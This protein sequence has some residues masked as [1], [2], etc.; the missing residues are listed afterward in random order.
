TR[1]REA[2][3]AVGLHQPGGDLE[4]CRLA[5]AVAPHQTHALAL[6]D[7]KLRALEQRRAAEGE[8]DVLQG[9]ERWRHAA[10]LA[11]SAARRNVYS[12]SPNRVDTSVASAAIT[13]FASGPVAVTV[14]EVPIPAASIIRPMIESPPTL[15]ALRETLTVA[16][17]FS[18]SCTNFADARACRP[19][20]LTIFITRVTA[21]GALARSSECGELISRQARGS[22]R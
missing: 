1:L 13:S 6:S 9:Q 22:R 7:R 19:F 11:A 21:P 14:I 15:S 10:Q 5:R 8:A 18:T 16:S 3:P 17:N 12:S 4:Q 2:H 20:S